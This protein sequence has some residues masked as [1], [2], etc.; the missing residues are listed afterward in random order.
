MTSRTT[1]QTSVLI[2]STLAFTACFAVW[3]MF[4]IIGI[5]IKTSLHLNE[6]EFGLLAATP[7]LTGSL[8]RL[9]VGMMTD[10]YGGRPVFFWLMVSI[11]IP[12]YLISYATE[13]WQFLVLGLF[14]GVAG[15]SFTVGIAYVARW[16]TREH[17]GFAMGIF[18][19]GNSGAAVTKLAAP[20]IVVAFGWQAVPQIYAMA[21]LAVVVMFWFFTYSDPNHKVEA[22]ITVAD[23][24]KVLRDPK[25][26]KYC[27]YYSLVFGGYVGL[28]L[29]LT[30]YFIGEY[31]HPIEKAALLAAIFVL[32]GG[33]IRAFG[34]YL[35][36]KFGAHTVTWWVMWVSMICLFL[37]AYPQTDVAIQTKGGEDIIMHLGLSETAFIVCL[38]IVGVC[39]GVGKAS[40]F[41]Y[42]SDDYSHNIGVVSGVVG[43]VGGMGGFLLPIMFGALLDYTGVHSTAFMLLFGA[44]L[45]SVLWM[46]YS[47]ER[48]KDHDARHA[49]AV[50]AME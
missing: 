14:V 23:Q 50:D 5:P 16:Y 45:V 49:K 40:V 20:S 32:P 12:I 8:L 3:M 18:G 41:K 33:V 15:A 42:L 7:V 43:L 26:W 6:L 47:G 9:P 10:K 44:T 17:Q 28:S 11:I 37:M 35:S 38:F 1:Q 2:M 31:G 19:A 34:G 21:M 4:S 46:Q 30:K 24:L 27:Q 48:Q 36:D 39:W 13:Y 25:V 22:H 29:W